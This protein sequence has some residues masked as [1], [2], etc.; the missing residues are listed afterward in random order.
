M[1]GKVKKSM[2][3]VVKVPQRTQLSVYID[4]TILCTPNGE[5]KIYQGRVEGTKW[6]TVKGTV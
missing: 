5:G 2:Y 4:L 6:K 3:R 1:F